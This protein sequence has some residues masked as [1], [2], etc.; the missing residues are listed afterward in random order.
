MDWVGR[1]KIF[2]IVPPN[3]FGSI[4]R[5]LPES[6]WKLRV[7]AS[8]ASAHRPQAIG[9]HRRDIN[10]TYSIVLTG[11]YE[12]CTENREEFTYIHRWQGVQGLSRNKRTA[13]QSFDQKLTETNSAR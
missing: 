10:G 1:T 4:S 5:V 6:H 8:K 9:I 11:F 7:Q 3:Y 13:E 12:E 2:T